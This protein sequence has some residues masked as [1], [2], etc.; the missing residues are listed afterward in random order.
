MMHDAVFE[1]VRQVAADVFNVDIHE[2]TEESTPELVENWDSLQQLT[3]LLSLESEFRIKFSTEEM[4]DILKI[5]TAVQ[6]VR[7]KISRSSSEGYN[8]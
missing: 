3:Y 1:R 4:G 8:E 5:K 2:I 6:I 7:D